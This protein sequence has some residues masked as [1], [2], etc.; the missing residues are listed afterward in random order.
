MRFVAADVFVGDWLAVDFNSAPGPPRPTRIAWP[1]S[2]CVAQ[3]DK[4]LLAIQQARV[5][6]TAG[7]IVKHHHF[8]NPGHV[9]IG[10]IVRGHFVARGEQVAM[11]EERFHRA[12]IF[13][14]QPHGFARREWFPSG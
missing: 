1:N 6:Y 8:E 7:R 5:V 9:E 2:N 14:I 13:A 3:V 12:G 10:A 11:R 4:R